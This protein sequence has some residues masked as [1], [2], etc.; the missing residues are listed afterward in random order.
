[1]KTVVKIC[2]CDADAL[3]RKDRIKEIMEK[4]FQDS[5]YK[6]ILAIF[7]ALGWSLAYPLIKIGYQEF[8]VISTDLG[9][10]IIFCRYSFFLC[11]TCGSIV[12]SVSKKRNRN[13]K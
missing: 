11:R 2:W 5:K 7:C 13:E 1:M 4:I 3:K 12:L 6:S 10:K 9:G 8:Q